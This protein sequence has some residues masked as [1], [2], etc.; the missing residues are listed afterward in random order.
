MAN[1]PNTNIP[2]SVLDGLKD[3]DP[4]KWNRILERLQSEIQNGDTKA[5]NDALF[6]VAFYSMMGDGTGKPGNVEYGR[7]EGNANVSKIHDGSW[8]INSNV[9]PVDWTAWAANYINSSGDVYNQDDETVVSWDDKLGVLHDGISIGSW[10][11]NDRGQPPPPKG[12]RGKPPVNPVISG[13]GGDS[14]LRKLWPDVDW[15]GGGAT[16]GDMDQYDWW[17]SQNLYQ[18]ST[19]LF[20]W[21]EVDPRILSPGDFGFSKDVPTADTQYPLY[22]YLNLAGIGHNLAYAPGSRTAWAERETAEDRARILSE[23]GTP[24]YYTGMTG[25]GARED[26]KGNVTY[27]LRDLM[28]YYGGE[29]PM[30]VP[31]GWTPQTPPGRPASEVLDFPAGGARQPVYPI[32]QTPLYPSGLLSPAGAL[33]EGPPPDEPP[34]QP[35]VQ[36][37]GGTIDTYGDLLAK[38]EHRMGVTPGTVGNYMYRVMGEPYKVTGVKGGTGPD[39]SYGSYRVPLMVYGGDDPYETIATRM[40]SAEGW[41]PTMN[42]WVTRGLDAGGQKIPGFNINFADWAGTPGAYVGTER[43]KRH[44]VFGGLLASPQN[45]MTEGPGDVAPRQVT[46][47]SGLLDDSLSPSWLSRRQPSV[48]STDTYRNWGFPEM[49]GISERGGG[50]GDVYGSGVIGYGIPEFRTDWQTVTDPVTGATIS[51]TNPLHP[52]FIG[53]DQ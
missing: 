22:N 12:V 14:N 24:T 26:A 9:E 46:W 32:A 41:D 17:E 18:E 52:D 8:T 21:P 23:G 15:D 39:R 35:P 20:D 34:V 7:G 45:V 50:A 31:G 38:Y 4:G 36:P 49:R 37:P 13:P 19:G 11:G 6:G 51:I 47:Q 16:S 48:F 40:S 1:I 10:G 44:P 53:A 28:Y 29:A 5:I 27:P 2:I 43:E 3:D 33:P 25:G 30:N 42:Q